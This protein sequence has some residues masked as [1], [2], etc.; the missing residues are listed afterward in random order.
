MKVSSVIYNKIRNSFEL[1]HKNGRRKIKYESVILPM[2]KEMNVMENIQVL[3]FGSSPGFEEEITRGEA[4]V[5]LKEF[6]MVKKVLFSCCIP[7][8]DN[9][10]IYP[11]IMKSLLNEMKMSM[12]LFELCKAWD[13]N[14]SIKKSM[15][16]Q[17]NVEKLDLS[18]KTKNDCQYLFK[19]V[20]G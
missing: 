6:V 7:A 13:G 2:K 5:S 15:K 14:Q 10:Y 19:F 9:L 17:D 12:R 1:E 18:I 3:I 20:S 11:E 4:M 16:V 8:D